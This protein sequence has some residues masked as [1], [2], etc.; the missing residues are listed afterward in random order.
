MVI[1]V[2]ELSVAPRLNVFET[3][4]NKSISKTFGALSAFAVNHKFMRVVRIRRDN[5]CFDAGL[6]SFLYVV[7]NAA[8][9]SVCVR[10]FSVGLGLCIA[11]DVNENTFSEGGALGNSLLLM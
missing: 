2:F 11:P 9:N 4:S 6:N 3:P 5:S 10:K 7:I 1:P 8:F